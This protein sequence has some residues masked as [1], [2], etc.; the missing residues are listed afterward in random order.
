MT[1]SPWLLAVALLC[2]L[3]GCTAAK[4]G[5]VPDVSGATASSTGGSAAASSANS[6][7]PADPTADAPAASVTKPPIDVIYWATPQTVVDK[8]LELA[9]LKPSDVVYDLGCGDARSLVTAA[10]RYGAKGFGFDID[11]R[12]VAEARE[13]VRQQGVENLVKIE[14][15]DI[16]TL[17]LSPADV[18]FLFL[19]TRLNERLKP[20][21][22]K[23]RPGTRI[24]SH[25]FD[26]P[27]AVPTRMVRVPGPPDGPPDTDPNAA[28]KMHTLYLWKVPWRAQPKPRGAE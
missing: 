28:P 23:L 9:R 22:E 13:N 7:L 3:A 24:V 5:S 11:P 17:D 25:E 12:R 19:L 10:R 2:V 20:Q 26:L 6:A 18:V 1:R 15:A 27:G 8:L 16:F 4:T 21:L 14:Q